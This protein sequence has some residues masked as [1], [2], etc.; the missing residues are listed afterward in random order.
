MTARLC[1]LPVPP[2]ALPALPA[3]IPGLGPV[4]AE[5]LAQVFGDAVEYRTPEPCADCEKSGEGLCRTHGADLDQADAYMG[6]A[7]VLGIEVPR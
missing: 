2:A 6:L 7:L 3:E 5:I 4:E 1:A